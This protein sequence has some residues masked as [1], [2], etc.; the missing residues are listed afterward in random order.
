MQKQ[1]P[2][3]YFYISLLSPLSLHFALHTRHVSSLSLCVVYYFARELILLVCCFYLLVQYGGFTA[4]IW[5]ARY[6]R[7]EVVSLLV[8]RG[9]DLNLQNIVSKTN[10][11]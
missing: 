7:A 5:A 3:A 9:A 11:T 4:L 1:Q 10:K 6:G 8:E 2:N